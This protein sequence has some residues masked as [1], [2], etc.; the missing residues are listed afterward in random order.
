MPMRA[1]AVQSCAR[2]PVTGGSAVM[3][4][5]WVFAGFQAGFWFVCVPTLGF[6][7]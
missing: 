3:L 2:Q 4:Q 6:T 1:S 7:V 5:H